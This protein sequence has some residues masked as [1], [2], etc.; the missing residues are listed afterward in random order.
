MLAEDTFL[1]LRLN[2]ALKVLE[3]VVFDNLQILL[4]RCAWIGVLLAALENRFR[5]HWRVGSDKISNVSVSIL[6]FYLA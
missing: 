5:L 4:S 6:K 3:C 2:A 1:A